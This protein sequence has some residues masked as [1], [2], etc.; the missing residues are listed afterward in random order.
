MKY[1]FIDYISNILT[2]T[3]GYRRMHDIVSKKVNVPIAVVYAVR[4]HRTEK[5][6]G[7]VVHVLV[8]H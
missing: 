1:I 8:G 3:P 7:P 4:S 5:R 2:L 6:Y